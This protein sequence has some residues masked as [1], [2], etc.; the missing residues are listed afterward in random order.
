M[1][2]PQMHWVLLCTN[3]FPAHTHTV[4]GLQ[5]GEEGA[6]NG[7]SDTERGMGRQD[8]A[9][10]HSSC[11]FLDEVDEDTKKTCEGL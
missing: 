6:R 4:V 11:P 1:I 2:V 5:V 9:A 10:D 7:T 8:E 3:L